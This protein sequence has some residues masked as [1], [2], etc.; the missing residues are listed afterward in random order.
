MRNIVGSFILCGIIAVSLSCS[1]PAGVVAE[2]EIPP[3]A[4][5][6]SA[7]LDDGNIELYA[8]Y[9]EPLK[10]QHGQSFKV[11]S[12]WRF[13]KQPPDGYKLF[14]H[15]EDPSG[16]QIFVYDHPL[17]DGRFKELPL[18]GLIRDDA[19]IK[20]LPVW[21]DSDRIALHAGFFKD[22]KRLTPDPKFND[23]KDRM[24]LPEIEIS[25]PKL[26]K[27]QL[28]VF[29]VAGE[30]RKQIKIDGKL[31]ESY[32]QNAQTGGKF[33]LTTGENTARQQ[34]NVLTAMDEK[35]LYFAFDCEDDDVHATLKDNDD[36]IYDHDDVVEI[37]IDANGDRK[38]YWEMQVSAAGVK[39]DASFKGG[40]RKNMDVSWDSG[41]KY[42]V[43]VNGTLNK[44]DDTDKG[45]TAEIAIPWKSIAD[46]VNNP[47]KDGDIWKAY[48]YRIDRNGSGRKPEF[49]AWVPPYKGDFHYLRFMG[50][51]VFVYEEIL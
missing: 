35:Y 36:K 10:P 48:L 47:P 22:D 45:W 14:F 50:D 15:F 30:S 9:T 25:K 12:F 3:Y 24:K 29:A 44:P 8:F 19:S 39:F 7:L 49:S 27:K 31:K 33:W 1:K 2:S 11:V 13:K 46:A 23:G 17:A 16:E 18:K 37:F 6:V 20:E 32:W 51:I 34:T 38:D 21:F 40:P 43:Q 42:A 26:V 41:I 4:Q 5:K 28:K